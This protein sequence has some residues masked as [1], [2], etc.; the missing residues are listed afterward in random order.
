MRP[1]D[2]FLDR[3]APR[4]SK[5]LGETPLQHVRDALQQVVDKGDNPAEVHYV[6]DIGGW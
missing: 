1:L 6:V 5:R 3:S 2:E 4:H